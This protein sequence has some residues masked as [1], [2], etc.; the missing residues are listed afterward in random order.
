MEDEQVY[1]LSSELTEFIWYKVLGKKED[2][3][4]HKEVDGL[5][6]DYYVPESQDIYD[7]VYIIVSNHLQPE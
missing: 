6:A 5:N 1:K 4:V 7:D 3:I 2:P